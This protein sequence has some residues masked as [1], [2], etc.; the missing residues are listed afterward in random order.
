VLE[1]VRNTAEIFMGNGF[2]PASALTVAGPTLLN[3]TINN[4]SGFDINLSYTVALSI[5]NEYTP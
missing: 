2:D 5:A 3:I 4:P 1:V